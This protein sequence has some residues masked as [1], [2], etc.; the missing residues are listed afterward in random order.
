MLNSLLVVADAGFRE[1][2]IEFY[3]IRESIDGKTVVAISMKNF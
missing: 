3:S 1:V 2:V